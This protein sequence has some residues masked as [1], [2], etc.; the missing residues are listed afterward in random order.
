MKT[1][2]QNVLFVVVDDLRPQL[3]CY[4]Q[5][6]ILCPNIDRMYEHDVEVVDMYPTL[7][8]LCGLPI[9]SHCESTSFA[10]LLEKPGRPWKRAAFSQYPRRGDVMGYTMRIER[11]RYTEWQE[12]ATGKVLARELYDHEQDPQENVNAAQK[13]GYAETIAQLAGELRQGWRAAQ[14]K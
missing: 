6:W 8:D 5:D 12:R 13:R 2:R 14:T 7:S 4:G 11:F 3:G 1:D 9:P 10:P